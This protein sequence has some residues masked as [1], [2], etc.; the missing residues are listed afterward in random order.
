MASKVQTFTSE[1]SPTP[2]G[3]SSHIA[4]V[5]EQITIGGVGGVDPKTGV[6]AGKDDVYEN[7][8][9]E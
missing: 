4:K 7:R 9:P 1:K 6:V 5:G 3:P 2:I 8:E